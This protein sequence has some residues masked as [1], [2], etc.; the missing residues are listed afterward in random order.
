MTKGRRKGVITRI[1]TVILHE[2]FTNV[3]S[4]FQLPQR[5]QQMNK[6]VEVSLKLKLTKCNQNVAK[7]L[8]N[9]SDEWQDI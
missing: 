2:I 8:A 6:L 9:Y 5:S 4:K 3:D 7:A 1:Q